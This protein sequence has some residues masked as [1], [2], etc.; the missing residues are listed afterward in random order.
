MQIE[1]GRAAGLDLGPAEESRQPAVFPERGAA[2]V[3]AVRVAEHDV[4]GQVLVERAQAVA[5]PRAEGRP[6]GEDFSRVDAAQPLRVVVVVAHHRADETDVVGH[7]ADVRQQLGQFHSA[8]AVLP[9]AEGRAHQQIGL[10]TRLKAL[11]MLRMPLAAALLQ[12]GLGIEQIDLAGPAVL[13]QQNDRLRPS[14]KMA[15]PRRKITPTGPL[16]F[17]SAARTAR[18]PPEQVRKRQRSEPQSG[19]FE[20]LTA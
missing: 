16:L 20:K 7:R 10:A 3:V 11:D 1:D 13:H 17:R 6:A 19:P 9:K 15:G 18:L 8:L 12:L 5:H 14:R 4:G 2:V